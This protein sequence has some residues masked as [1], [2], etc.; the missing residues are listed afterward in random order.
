MN[1]IQFLWWE[2]VKTSEIYR[3]MTFQYAVT[4]WARG[5]FY[6]WVETFKE[7]QTSN[8][9]DVSCFFKPSCNNYN[10]WK[11]K[12]RLLSTALLCM[13]YP[14]FFIANWSKDTVNRFLCV[15]QCGPASLCAVLQTLGKLQTDL[16][17]LSAL[18]ERDLQSSLLQDLIKDTVELLSNIQPFIQNLNQ[19]ATRWGTVLVNT[20]S[21]R[22]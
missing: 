20:A 10:V 17:A 15:L 2:G 4:V 12:Q 1:L 5:K 13:F 19:Q 7:G 18:A 11:S 14:W 3:I 16:Q 22:V 9:D 8:I 21:L 6:K